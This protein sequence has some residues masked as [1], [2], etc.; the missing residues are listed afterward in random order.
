MSNT[1]APAL[2]ALGQELHKFAHEPLEGCI[3]QLPDESN[4][5]NWDVA[6]F[7]PPDTLYQGGYFKVSQCKNEATDDKFETFIDNIHYQFI[8]SDDDDDL[9]SRLSILSLTYDKVISN[10]F[11]NLDSKYLTEIIIIFQ[12]TIMAL[13]VYTIG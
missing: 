2:R 7:G 5:F 1:N 8:I 9:R 12:Y 6:I 10:L 13:L 11:V 3:I 4:L